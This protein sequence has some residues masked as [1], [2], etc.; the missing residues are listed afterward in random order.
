MNV[1]LD[2][3][4]RLAALHRAGGL[5]NA[6][7]E[8]EKA[9]LLAEPQPIPQQH[10]FPSATAEAQLSTTWQRRF[11]FF[12][13]YGS[14]LRQRGLQAYRKLPWRERITIGINFW[15][16]FLGPFY[17]FYLGLWK[18]GLSLSLAIILVNWILLYLLG[19][20]LV[21]PLDVVYAALFAS[22][23]NYYR[24]IKVTEGRDEWNPLKDILVS[25]K[26]NKAG[27]LNGGNS[28]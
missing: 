18:R 20:G 23:A 1:N 25:P 3:L 6:E 7:Y 22:T 28:L 9:K 19:D 17:F 21:Q 14:P 13:T 11:A 16:L 4:E 26:G 2:R 8:A 5:T 15:G 10:T 24:F 12:Q 27:P